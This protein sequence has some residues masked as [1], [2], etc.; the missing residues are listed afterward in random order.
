MFAFVGWGGGGG[1]ARDNGLCPMDLRYTGLLWDTCN[2]RQL[3]KM[4]RSET[5][6]VF[7]QHTEVI[8]QHTIQSY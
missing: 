5:F 2:F 3:L 4:Q 1:D 7:L 6:L 8:V